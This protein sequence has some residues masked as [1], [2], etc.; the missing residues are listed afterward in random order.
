M[1]SVSVTV[2]PVPAIL[3]GA[4]TIILAY[5]PSLIEPIGLN[6]FETILSV[7]GLFGGPLLGAFLLGALFPIA[8][9]MVCRKCLLTADALSNFVNISKNT[10]L[11]FLCDPVF[12]TGAVQVPTL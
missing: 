6:V 8:N 4:V 11:R 12:P 10:I 2:V 1:S 5:I 3:Y 7:F 9:G